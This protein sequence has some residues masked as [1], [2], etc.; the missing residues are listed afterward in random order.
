MISMGLREKEIERFIAR[1]WSEAI[2]RLLNSG[3]LTEKCLP[4]GV[5]IHL[6]FHLV[7][8]YSLPSHS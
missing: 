7:V 6:R 8:L 5:L 1:E 3:S 2:D 4:F